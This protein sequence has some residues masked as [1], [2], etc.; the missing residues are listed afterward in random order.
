MFEKLRKPKRAKNIAYYVV[1]GLICLV[2]VFIGVPVSQM[3]NMGG[4]AIIVNNKVI[5]W[6][7]YRRYLEIL[8][9]RQSPA[10]LGEGLEA[11]RQERLRYEALSAL[12]SRELITQ[13]SKK[14]GL[15]VSE[16]QVRDNILDIPFFQEEGRFTRS[17]YHSFLTA[18]R[19]SADYFETGIRKEIETSRFQNMFNFTV[20]S[21]VMEKEKN[22]ILSSFKI[23]VSYISFSSLEMGAEEFNSLKAFVQEGDK[24]LLNQIIKEKKWQWEKT[25]SFNLDRV[26]LPGLESQKILFKSMLNHLPEMGLVKKIVSTGDKSYILRVDKFSTQ[27]QEEVKPPFPFDGDFFKNRMASRT[28]FL[29]WMRLVRSSAKIKF[30]PKLQDIALSLPSDQ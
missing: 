24:E 18:S 30:N 22:N 12:L 21:S 28:A 16:S 27:K 20:R 15:V 3:S 17:K 11:K 8:D 10:G 6:S 29:S 14:S 9:R 2:F 7:E 23:Q 25:K 13:E 5:S 26:S 19:M 1:F 4:A